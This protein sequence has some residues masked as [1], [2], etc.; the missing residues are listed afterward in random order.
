MTDQ[1]LHLAFKI[2]IG[3]YVA[4]SAVITSLPAPTDKSSDKYRWWYQFLTTLLI[5]ARNFKGGK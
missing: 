1:Q 2:G 3:L 5:N 4:A